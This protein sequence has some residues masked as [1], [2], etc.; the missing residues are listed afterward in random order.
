MQNAAES[1]AL[2]TPTESLSTQ[3]DVL[4]AVI[5]AEA[6][7]VDYLTGLAISQAMQER[8]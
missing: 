1:K 7:D 3:I 2:P 6:Y 5:Y 4:L 8:I